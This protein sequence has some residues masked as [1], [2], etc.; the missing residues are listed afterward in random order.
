MTAPGTR[1]WVGRVRVA[2]AAGVIDALVTWQ[3]TRTARFWLS[4]D[5]AGDP[6]SAGSPR[7]Q[8]CD[9]AGDAA[10]P[11]AGDDPCIECIAPDAPG[12][13]EPTASGPV[14]MIAW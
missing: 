4:R 6:A 1:S 3:T 10:P 8:G 11:G 5:S 9:G 2:G 7:F 14:G 13:A 12:T